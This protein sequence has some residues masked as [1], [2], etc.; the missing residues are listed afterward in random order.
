MDLLSLETSVKYM[1]TGGVLLAAVASD[2]VTRSRRR[3]AG[4]A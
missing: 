3:S 1:V 4:R 2:A